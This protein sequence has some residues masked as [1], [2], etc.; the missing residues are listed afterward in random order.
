MVVASLLH[1]CLQSQSFL[2]AYHTPNTL[3]RK[4]HKHAHGQLGHDLLVRFFSSFV[5]WRRSLQEGAWRKV[6]DGRDTGSSALQYRAQSRRA[7][8]HG[9]RG[10]A[11][12]QEGEMKKGGEMKAGGGD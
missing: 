4:K 7:R 5:C 3:R 1:Q 11:G 2:S 10:S 8:P 6:P 12:E 9:A